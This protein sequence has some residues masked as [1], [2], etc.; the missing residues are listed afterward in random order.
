M[1]KKVKGKQ[2]RKETRKGESGEDMR[3]GEEKE[4]VE[5]IKG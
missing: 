4:E 3:K 5:W 2:G 1:D